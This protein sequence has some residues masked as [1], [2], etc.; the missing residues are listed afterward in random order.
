MQHDEL[1]AWLRLSLTPGLGNQGARKLLTAFGLPQTIWQQTLTA[2]AQVLSP[3][4][5]Q[6]M[7][8]EP[9]ALASTLAQTEAWL[10]E[11]KSSGQNR[12]IAVLGDAHYP[13]AL[14]NLDDPP[15]MLY[16]LGQAGFNPQD[17]ASPAMVIRSEACLAM[18]GSRNPTPQGLVNARQ[19]AKAMVQSGLTVVSGLA[20]G[21]DGAAH[22]GA[23]EAFGDESQTAA[24]VAIVGT[25]LDR[26]YPKAHFDLAHRVAQNGLLISEY[27]LGTA[28]LSGNFPKRN[29]LIAGLSQGTLVVEAALQSG[30]LIS[31]RLSSE[32]GKEV[33]A[34]PGSIHA[35]QYRGCHAL[36]K[37][38][39]K[40]VES[41]Q[42]ILEEM[43]WLAPQTKSA[44][45]NHTSSPPTPTAE[46]AEQDLLDALG[47]DPVSLDA[48]SARTGQTTATLQ[49][50]L[51][52]L[53][54]QGLVA[55]LP[56]GL[57]QRQVS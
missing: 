1:S 41:A 28:P 45:P 23:L 44:G 39:A 47:Y 54:L 55:R 22:E 43:R 12:R 51:M 13:S 9:E 7:Q 30:S 4:Q 10:E 56:G 49:A 16:L 33:F 52:T 6:A 57:F 37:Q 34:I 14:L 35:A 50:G 20:L 25:G 27:P 26:V 24:T 21:I 46:H 32:Q 15:L 8:A 19:F 29:R 17:V 53:E 5:V 18:V 31:A 40:L 48:L 38:G 11:G 3:A 2:L 36:I 42:D